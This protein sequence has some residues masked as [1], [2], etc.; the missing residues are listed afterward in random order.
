MYR[1]GLTVEC[2]KCGGRL[3]TTRSAPRKTEKFGPI[4]R[5]RKMC[6]ECGAQFYTVE[7]HERIAEEIWPGVTGVEENKRAGSS[8]L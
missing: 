6:R 2:E 1:R 3:L 5:R 8:K 7:I 4:V